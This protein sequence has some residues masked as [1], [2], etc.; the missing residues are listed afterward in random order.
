MAESKHEMREAAIK[1]LKNHINCPWWHYRAMIRDIVGDDLDV[2]T[3]TECVERVI[4]LL[5]DDEPSHDVNL[6]NNVPQDSDGVLWLNGGKLGGDTIPAPLIRYGNI[7]PTTVRVETQR[8]KDLIGLIKDA[9]EDYKMV[10]RLLDT[11]KKEDNATAGHTSCDSEEYVR[12]PLDLDGKPI[13]I[14]DVMKNMFG[15]EHFTVLGI[16]NDGCEDVL[17]CEDDDLNCQCYSATACVHYQK[18]TIQDI[19]EELVSEAYSNGW[20]DGSD[21]TFSY[22]TAELVRE[23]TDRLENL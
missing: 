5:T 7:G 3:G 19:V 11:Y 18:P 10:T 14:G 23:Y 20:S 9:A 6:L 17:F 12:L 15:P 13:H 2:L 1:R 16:G 8:E 22:D 4:D 21:D